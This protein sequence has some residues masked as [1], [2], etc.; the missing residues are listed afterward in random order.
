M[1]NLPPEDQEQLARELN[2]LRAA[3]MTDTVKVLNLGLALMNA[4]GEAVL[5][6]AVRSLGAEI[7]DG[8]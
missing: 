4:V 7:R 2:A 5:V 3:D 1:Q 8:S 6:A